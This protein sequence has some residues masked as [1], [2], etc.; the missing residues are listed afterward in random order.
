M[1]LVVAGWVVVCSWAGEDISCRITSYNVCYTKLLRIAFRGDSVLAFYD[2]GAV[3]TGTLSE[4]T[5][6]LKA[7]IEALER[8]LDEIKAIRNN[9]V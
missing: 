5:A 9:F 3:K 6:A 1:G 8:E 4:D 7:R 2:N